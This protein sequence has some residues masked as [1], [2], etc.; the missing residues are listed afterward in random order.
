MQTDVH[1]AGAS[2]WLA[3]HA[4]ISFP[5]KRPLSKQFARR[6]KMASAFSKAPAVK[7][8]GIPKVGSP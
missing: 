1:T 6:E 5:H 2:C 4:L 3:V 7:R 8:W